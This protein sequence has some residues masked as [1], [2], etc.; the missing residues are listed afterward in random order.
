MGRF[1]GV[2]ELQDLTIVDTSQSEVL[3]IIVV[4]NITHNIEP[5]V[6]VGIK[7]E[8]VKSSLQSLVEDIES[9]L[10]QEINIVLSVVDTVVN[11]AHGGVV[12]LDQS[13]V[14]N[15]TLDVSICGCIGK[16]VSGIHEL[17][18]ILSSEWVETFNDLGLGEAKVI[19]KG[20][21]V[22]IKI[23]NSSIDLSS[24][25]VSDVREVSIFDLRDK[26]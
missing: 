23:G 22:G 10:D 12:D 26:I 9:D 18:V 24:G 21:E 20:I 8:S 2:L 14:L 3:S 16:L 6:N 7:V 11:L 4:P 15:N 19:P 13:S 1:V 25:H 5:V 17:E